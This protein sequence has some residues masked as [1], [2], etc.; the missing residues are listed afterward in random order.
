MHAGG[1]PMEWWFMDEVAVIH[2]PVCSRGSSEQRLKREAEGHR[3][4]SFSLA[5]DSPIG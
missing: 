2:L 1:P 4:F 5:N 3:R